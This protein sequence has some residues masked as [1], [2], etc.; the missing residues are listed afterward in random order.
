[1]RPRFSSALRPVAVAENGDVLLTGS[2]DGSIDFGGT[3]LTAVGNGDVFI[4]RYAAADGSLT[5]VV[6]FGGSGAEDPLGIALDPSGNITLAGVVAGSVTLGGP[7][8]GTVGNTNEDRLRGAIDQPH[9]DRGARRVIVLAAHSARSAVRCPAMPPVPSRASLPPEAA[10]AP[11]L[12]VVPLL[13]PPDCSTD[14]PAQ[15][16]VSDATAKGRIRDFQRIMPRRSARCVPRRASARLYVRG[17][18]QPKCRQV[19]GT[20]G[21]AR[22]GM[23]GWSRALSLDPASARRVQ[24]LR[25][26]LGPR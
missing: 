2:Y 5:K 13:E 17:E 10:R 6:G 20:T 14:F 15:A 24:W 3:T 7:T 12:L 25:A 9:L 18:N 16:G 19:S 8:I 22:I 23:P 11:A 21:P 1:L 4:A 26:A